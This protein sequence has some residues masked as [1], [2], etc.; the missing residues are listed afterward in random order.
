MEEW[1]MKLSDMESKIRGKDEEIAEL[2]KKINELE[3]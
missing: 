2:K 3:T 1:D